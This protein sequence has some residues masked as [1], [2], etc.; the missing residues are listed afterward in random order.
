MKKQ[1][2]L[3]GSRGILGRHI[4]QF[5]QKDFDIVEFPSEVWDYKEKPKSGTTVVF[6][7][8]IS[9]PYQASMDAELS[10]NINVTK[11]QKLIEK[12]LNDSCRILFAST[13]LVYGQ[14]GYFPV[15]EN[16]KCNPYGVYA[17]QKHFIESKFHDVENFASMRFSL[18]YGTG[19][20]LRREF[21]QGKPS[22]IPHPVI[23]MPIKAVEAAETV[24]ALAWRSGPH[25]D[26]PDKTLN[27]GGRVPRTV[28]S[29][30]KKE[31]KETRNM[32]PIKVS[33]EYQ[34]K[35]SRPGRVVMC[36]GLS[37]LIRNDRKRVSL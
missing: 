4:V 12:F 6:M 18:L 34:D 32:K 17:S 28:F 15:K 10:E 8:A 35:I 22:E 14:T 19:S 16:S 20:K 26:L 1:L 11:T 7:R 24:F 9:S 5:P 36:S 25:F 30:A 33:R 27:V 23:R 29:L 37:R 31:A 3:V 21:Q 13:D 2:L